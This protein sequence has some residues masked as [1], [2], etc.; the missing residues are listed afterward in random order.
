MPKRMLI[1]AHRGAKDLA[2]E[3]T[4]EAFAKAIELKADGV[5]TDVQVTSS[6]VPIMI[7]DPLKNDGE[8]L[9]TLQATLELFST[10]TLK[11][12]LELKHQP[13]SAAA[14]VAAVSK[15][16]RP[17]CGK[18]DLSFSSFSALLLWEAQKQIP[19]VPRALLHQT[20]FGLHSLS[21]L[22]VPLLATQSITPFHEYLTPKFVAWAKQHHQKLYAWTVNTEADLLR[23][24]QLGLD[25]VMT[26]H[27]QLAQR[28][29]QNI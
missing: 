22:E 7:H 29:L 25:G 1:F 26:D 14:A 12:I 13:K 21:R 4:L 11:V 28:V 19:Q 20:R 18:I 17:F 10:S 27:V 6:D 16:V 23:C 5:E 9:P 3:N 2:P 8:D 24:Q 15:V